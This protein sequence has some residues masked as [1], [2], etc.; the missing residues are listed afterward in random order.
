[1]LRSDREMGRENL[2]MRLECNY[3][4]QT[5]VTHQYMAHPLRLSGVFRLDTADPQRP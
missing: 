3:V 2:E 5:V 4:G 1:M